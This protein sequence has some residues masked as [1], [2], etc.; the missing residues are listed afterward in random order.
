MPVTPLHYP[1]AYE[2]SKIDRRL[3]LPGLVVGSVMP[4]IEVPILWFF[5][6]GVLPDH[7][8][9]HSFIGALTIGTALAVL[10]TRFL[11]APIISWFFGVDRTKL[12]LMG[13]LLLDYTM[14]WFN[15]LFWPWMDP[16]AFVGPLVILF[17]PFGGLEGT[18]FHLANYLVSGV[19]AFLWLLII[20]KYRNDNLWEHIW[21]GE[22]LS[23][24]LES[25]ESLS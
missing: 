22:S 15:P 21:L 1:A 25:V 11:Y 13:H 14:H 2:L 7:L 18:P 6:T 3:S 5:F 24:K 9:L 12:G 4:D 17:S 20:I 23:P 10:T 19:M 16:F 8:I